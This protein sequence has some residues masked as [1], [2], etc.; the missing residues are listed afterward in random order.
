MEVRPCAHGGVIL[1]NGVADDAP[2]YFECIFPFGDS[3]DF[4]LGKEWKRGEEGGEE[5]SRFHGGKSRRWFE[6]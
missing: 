2:E 6:Y 4:L 5:E 3:I 1:F